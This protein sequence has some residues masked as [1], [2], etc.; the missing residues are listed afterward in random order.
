MNTRVIVGG[1]YGFVRLE[2]EGVD[3][4]P[5]EFL[6]VAGTSTGGHYEMRLFLR[7]AELRTMFHACKRELRRLRDAHAAKGVELSREIGEPKP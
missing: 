5:A 7:E 3:L 1:N 2:K 4:G 6:A